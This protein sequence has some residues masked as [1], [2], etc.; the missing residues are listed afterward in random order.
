MQAVRE[1]ASVV[2]T[3]LD[4]VFEIPLFSFSDGDEDTQWIPPSE[5]TVAVAAIDNG[6]HTFLSLS[7]CFAPPL[8]P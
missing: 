6:Q 4:L 7:R 5:P 2:R 1:N 3:L 8:L